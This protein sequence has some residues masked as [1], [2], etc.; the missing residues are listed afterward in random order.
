[1]AAAY[2]HSEFEAAGLRAV[3]DMRFTVTSPVEFEGALTGDDVSVRVYGFW[4]N[5]VR[6]VTTPPGGIHG[7][8]L[9]GG[10]G[11]VPELDGKEIEGSIVALEYNSG[12]N[13]LNVPALGGRA[14]LFIEPET[15]T[16]YESAAKF[17]RTPVNVPRF[18]ISRSDWT[19]IQRTEGEKFTLEGGMSWQDVTE[20]NVIGWVRG[21][22]EEP[23]PEG[24]VLADEVVVISAYYD[25]MSVVPAI[26]PGAE[27]ACGIAVLLDLARFVA[28][29]PPPRSVL[30]L[31]TSGHGLFM[32]GV[33]AFFDQHRKQL[34][35]VPA[36]FI[37][38]DLASTG[39]KVGAFCGGHAYWDMVLGQRLPN[40]FEPIGT[41]LNQIAHRTALTLGKYSQEEYLAKGLDR[42][43]LL[44][45]F[46]ESLSGTSLAKAGVDWGF[47]LPSRMAHEAETALLFGQLAYAFVT[48]G[49]ERP[50]V[51]SPLDTPE[52]INPENLAAQARFL[53]P[54][55]MEML[56]SR[57]P[58]RG[59]ITRIDQ[60]VDWQRQGH[61]AKVFPPSGI[62]AGEVSGRVV[63][64]VPKK[65]YIPDE[66]KD[67]ALVVVRREDENTY[68]GVR[69]EPVQRVRT[70]HEGD[71]E[72]R[73]YF[74]FANVAR[75]MTNDFTSRPREIE[76]YVLDEETGDVTYAKD[77]G[78]NGELT[79][80][81]RV[82][83]QTA[84]P[85]VRRTV[86]VFR[87][88]AIDLFDTF[89]PRY[90]EILS[91]IRV[92]D[93]RTDT[94]PESWG[95]AMCPP[96]GGGGND[97]G[98]A[99]YYDPCA[100]LFV[101][102]RTGRAA[103][104]KVLG[105]A[106]V[107]GQRLTL[108]D[109]TPEVPEGDGIE[110]SAGTIHHTAL[111]AAR[112]MIT[113]NDFRIE[114]LVNTGILSA[115]AT[116]AADTPKVVNL[117]SEL[118]HRSKRDL[119]VAAGALA[120]KDYSGCLELARSAWARA[121][122]VY[123]LVLRTGN[124]A[125]LTVLFYLALLLPGAFFLERMLCGFPDIGRQLAARAAIFAVVFVLLRFVNPAFKLAVN[126]FMV[127][128][129]F[130]MIA[131]TLAVLRVILK[132]LQE[133]LKRLRAQVTG[134]HNVEIGRSEA[135]G[136][137]F[138][139]GIS[140]MRK[141]KVRTAN[142]LVTLVVLMFSVLSF[143]SVVTRSELKGRAL[144]D[145]S[146]QRIAAPYAGVLFRSPLFNPIV[147]DTYHH[148][149]A[150]FAE[151]K[152]IAPRA[153]YP[154][155]TAPMN[156]A[157]RVDAPNGTSAAVASL[158]GL[159]SQEE[160]IALQNNTFLRGR[161]FDPNDQRGVIVPQALA[162]SLG[163]SESDIEKVELSMLGRRFVVRGIL[164]DDFFRRQGGFLDLDGEP[165]SPVNFGMSAQTYQEAV[166]TRP[167]ILAKKPPLTF[168][169]FDALNTLVIPFESALELG[170]SIRSVAIVAEDPRGMS[171]QMLRDEILSKL[172][173]GVFVGM[174]GKSYWYTSLGQ[175]DYKGLLSLLVLILIAGLIV[176][177]T[178]LGSLYER[179][180]EI[181]IYTSLGLAPSHI[182]A[183][184]L[185]ESCVYAVLGCLF[186]YVLGQTVAGL[187]DLFQ[188]DTL[189]GLTLNY[190]SRSALYATVIVAGVVLLSS[191]YPAWKASRLSV[192]E[193]E[194]SV[195]MPEPV[196]DEMTL[197]FPFTF[198]G[199]TE[200][201]IAAFLHKYLKDHEE[202]AVGPFHAQGTR[203]T[204]SAGG[205]QLE[206]K[207]WLAPFDWGISQNVA[208]TVTYREGQPVLV[209]SLA[210][211]EGE[212]KAWQRVNRRFVAD[213]RRQ[214]LL[215]RT[216]TPEDRQ[217]YVRDGQQTLATRA[218]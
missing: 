175:A 149:R 170:G 191:L 138:G 105:G 143:T 49:A 147:P 173:T 84:P 134:I 64:F 152:I 122:R 182:G 144:Y 107:F 192:P 44:S 201:G 87:C 185:A 127:L 31:A 32:E 197:E 150:E 48:W 120:R 205:I 71:R 46:V 89:D 215:W 19:L 121:S 3:R 27:Q 119:A 168:S 194:R 212:V 208:F 101:D 45:P 179:Q 207:I 193:L 180:R 103:R 176:F 217:R 218:S 178:V 35:V 167:D 81:T 169:H 5:L 13:W 53:R 36:T 172:A 67:N 128:L 171:E 14:V 203:L 7:S 39:D 188:V 29:H 21:T 37:A 28:A 41:Q 11:T 184:F 130:V 88:R 79:Y 132:M 155:G 187:R 214:L 136:I 104:I 141:R 110:V 102:R 59:F 163:L 2:I 166:T 63:E 42:N 9:Y 18:L 86:V 77:L 126:P 156:T 62:N 75:G 92:L 196:N 73:A 198:S 137:A 148:L 146:L 68:L 12:R 112:D 91:S 83:G 114:R 40:L 22:A 131:L 26:A 153:W 17:L 133:E 98:A 80:P 108:L 158:L 90:M 186:G 145:Q 160:R 57:D 199:G 93:G 111:R 115:G 47:T 106:G 211:L 66:P 72:V 38:L 124:D 34:G 55:L 123:P 16:H 70:V 159:S 142:T 118:H 177:N 85:A 54:M 200:V 96:S 113:L 139:L 56:N 95:L 116:G 165:L 117:L 60:I 51:D 50:L 30:F 94:E 129:G 206:T 20:T 69:C 61:R 181:G 151:A 210:R 190:S 157:I 23:D 135:A 204:E 97:P 76:A 15:T 209:L 25:S 140:S 52:R 109:A 202:L 10:S 65:N 213:L 125:V 164:A 78:R 195:R 8:L 4:P 74:R 24:R 162:R 100:T 161:W 189:A 1:M 154:G 33:T 82:Y 174:G 58:V 216:V 6:T 183:F 99:R 43:P